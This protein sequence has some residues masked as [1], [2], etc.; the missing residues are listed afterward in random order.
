MELFL[1]GVLT[2]SYATKQRHILQAKKMQTAIQLRWKLKSPWG[3]QA[4]HIKWFLTAYLS[5]HAD[6]T[7]YYYHLTSLLIEERLGKNNLR[8]TKF[9]SNKTQKQSR[10][11]KAATPKPS[12]KKQE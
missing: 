3:W 10:A 2:G 7:R 8:K 5:S 12:V 4:K 11:K 9:K 1:S 6:S